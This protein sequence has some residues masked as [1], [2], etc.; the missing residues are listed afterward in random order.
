MAYK[1]SDIESWIG[2]PTLAFW[3]SMGPTNIPKPKGGYTYSDND[4]FATMSQGSAAAYAKKVLKDVELSEVNVMNVGPFWLKIGALAEKKRFGRCL[5]LAGM[6]LLH[7]VENKIFNN[8]TIRIV[9]ARNYDHHF[10]VLVMQ[11]PE[12]EWQY[13]VVD[14]WQGCVDGS[15]KFVYNYNGYYYTAG[16]VD[17]LCE[18][19][20][21]SRDKDLVMAKNA[22]AT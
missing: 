9:G 17:V 13:F 11:N 5:H 16:Q 8:V 14:I 18:F 20:G 22:R 4:K 6:A 15:K 2:E 19:R 7:L 21:G 12:K 10:V 3:K 1:V